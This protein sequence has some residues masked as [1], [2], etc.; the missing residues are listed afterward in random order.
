MVHKGRIDCDY[1]IVG[2]THRLYSVLLLMHSYS[3]FNY[4][5]IWIARYDG[6]CAAIESSIVCTDSDHVTLCIT[7][8]YSIYGGICFMEV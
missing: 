6:Y 1:S 3:E 4:N 5:V 2:T 8:E 7:P